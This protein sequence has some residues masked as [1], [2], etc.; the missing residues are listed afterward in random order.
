MEKATPRARRVGDQIQRELAGLVTEELGDP[1]IG[2]VTIS[3]VDVSR[4]LRVAHVRVTV[5][6]PERRAES[7]AVLRR[8]AG[9]LR[10]AL[11]RRMRIRTVPELRFEFDEATE[12]GW[13]VSA[14][15]DAAHGRG[16]A[17]DG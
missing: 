1:R 8:A 3:S 16:P 7:L 9:Y 11:S 17:G 6:Q 4:D 10:H 14:L 2:M 13:R 5:L 12:R 15:I